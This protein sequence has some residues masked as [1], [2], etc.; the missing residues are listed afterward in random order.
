MALTI[1]NGLRPYSPCTGAIPLLMARP[2]TNG[3]RPGFPGLNALKVYSEGPGV[4]A[5]VRQHYISYFS[6]GSPT[7]RSGHLL[8]LL[9]MLPVYQV[10]GWA[11]GWV[12]GG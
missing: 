9:C 1:S 11:A 2:A 7:A 12:P 4:P 6:E 5:L 3:L 8:L 10:A